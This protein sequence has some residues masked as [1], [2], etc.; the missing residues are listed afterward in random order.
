MIELSVSLASNGVVSVPGYEQ[1][2]RFGYTKNRGV[3]RLKVSASG[4]WAGLTVRCFWHLPGGADPASTLVVDG[5]ADVPASVTAVSGGGCI[6]F[7]SDG[8]V[9]FKTRDYNGAV[10]A[11]YHYLTLDEMMS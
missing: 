8:T 7:A 2:L 11:C 3:Y 5:Y 10:C 6:T 4:E 1:L 9:T